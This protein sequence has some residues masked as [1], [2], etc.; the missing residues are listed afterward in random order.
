MHISSCGLICNECRFY[1]NSCPGCFRV[2]GKTFWAKEQT[3]E[4]ICPLFACAAQKTLSNCGDC[5]ELPCQRFDDLKDP[6]LSEEEHRK[7]IQKRVD[8][9]QGKT[10]QDQLT[11]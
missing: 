5:S 3:E 2:E 9:L 8:M 6:D 4:G 11:A 7:M 10:G 1:A